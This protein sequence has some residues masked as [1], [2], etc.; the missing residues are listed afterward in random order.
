[1]NIKEIMELAD[2]KEILEKLCVDTVENRNISTNIKQYNGKHD[3]LNRLDKNIGKAPEELTDG[4][5]TKDTRK[6]VKQAK[7]VLRLQEKIVRDKSIFL[8]GKPVKLILENESNQLKKAF[9][10]LKTTLKDVKIDS[11]N[12]KLCKRVLVESKAAE[13]WYIKPVLEP[14][15]NDELQL[16]G[17]EI[18]VY[19][20]CS[21]NGD[22]IYPHFNEFGDMDAFTRKYSVKNEK[23]KNIAYVDIYTDD[24]IY[25]YVKSQSGNSYTVKDEKN[26]IG[27]IPIVYYDQEEAEWIKVQSLIDRLEKV[28]SKHADIN[29]YFS[30]P[31]IVG[32]G[33]IDS[34]PDKDEVGKFFEIEGEIG[35]DGKVYYGSLEYLTWDQS[36]ESMK[37]EITNLKDFINSLTHTPDL[38]FNNLKNIGSNLSGIAIKFMFFDS[39][40]DSYDKQEIFGEGLDRRNNLLKAILSFL[41]T[42]QANNIQ[43]LEITNEFSS[44][45]PDNYVEIINALSESR[46]GTN[47]ISEE[48]AAKHHPFIKKPNDEIDRL[49]QEK[50]EENGG[51]S[52]I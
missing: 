50:K 28:I 39:I 46:P 5:I 30:S 1:M 16:K 43:Q 26:L 33:E 19:L 36:P 27:K 40:L 51:S 21:K 35:E 24:M 45:L 38:S 4:T 42:A 41:N 18:K 13:L 23:G 20:L 2:V 22:E 8:F 48:T 14:N 47:L 11:F 3:I 31:S 32:K 9:D 7:L 25:H 49:K 37:L 17:T 34:A 10:L 44:I 6:T 12:K 29:D 15:E 52:E